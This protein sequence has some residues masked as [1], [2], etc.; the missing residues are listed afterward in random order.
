MDLTFD[1]PKQLVIHSFF[2]SCSVKDLFSLH[3]LTF[4]RRGSRW[5]CVCL[6]RAACDTHTDRFNSDCSRAK[7]KE[8]QVKDTKVRA[9]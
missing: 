2:H 1:T 5:F 3:F 6:L 7:E 9:E 4:M 8:I